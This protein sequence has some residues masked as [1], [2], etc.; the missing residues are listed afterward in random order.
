MIAKWRTLLW[1]VSLLL[2]FSIW[3]DGYAQ[4]KKLYPVD[5]AVKDQMDH[6][7][8]LGEPKG[9]CCQRIPAKP[10]R[11][12]CNLRKERRKVVNDRFHCRRLRRKNADETF[13]FSTH[14][15]C[16]S[17]AGCFVTGSTNI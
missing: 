5:E 2:L 6:S 15:Y 14:N 17:S 12:P 1:I 11:L 13:E 8:S 9:L 10:D 3:T 4:V 7:G 16:T